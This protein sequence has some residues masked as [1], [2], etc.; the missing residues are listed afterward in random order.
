[1]N[2]PDAAAS[3]LRQAL[4]LWRGAPL[5]GLEHEPFAA[6]AARRL[7]ELKLAAQEDRIEAGLPWR[8]VRRPVTELEALVRE[9]PFREHLRGL[10]MLALYREGRQADALA[11]YRQTRVLYAEE[12]GLE[13][14]PELLELERSILEHESSLRATSSNG[15]S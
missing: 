10:L 14:S 13:P 12:L 9:H 2:R 11:L 7:E 8:G 15:G 6:D 3:R 5:A 4:A 1:A